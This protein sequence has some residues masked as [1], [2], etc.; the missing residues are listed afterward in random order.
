MAAGLSRIQQ[1]YTAQQVAAQGPHRR[2]LDYSRPEDRHYQFMSSPY[3]VSTSL[4]NHEDFSATAR[5]FGNKD[6]VEN[7]I[8]CFAQASYDRQSH[9]ELIE[10]MLGTKLFFYPVTKLLWRSCSE[11]RDLYRLLGILYHVPSGTLLLR[12]S[13]GR[14]YRPEQL[15]FGPLPPDFVKRVHQA[16]PWN[17]FLYYASLIR[18][19]R[20]RSGTLSADYLAT[21]SRLIPDGLPVLCSLQKL[22]WEESILGGDHLL[23][24]LAPSVTRLAISVPH[25]RDGSLND[26]SFTRWLV[27][28]CDLLSVLMPHL[29]SLSIRSYGRQPPSKSATSYFDTLYTLPISVEGISAHGHRYEVE[30]RTRNALQEFELSSWG[31]SL[32]LFTSLKTIHWF[33][34]PSLRAIQITSNL[35]IP[36][37]DAP[38][39]LDVIA[40]ILQLQQL[41]YIDILFTR[42]AFYFTEGEMLA[43]AKA[44]P[45]LEAIDLNFDAVRPTRTWNEPTRTPPTIFGFCTFAA[46][47]PSLNHA[48]LP[49][50]EAC[51]SRAD[52]PNRMEHPL[53]NVEFG[54]L[55]VMES[56][57]YDG[58]EV[59]HYHVVQ[60][61]LRAFPKLTANRI[62]LGH[63]DWQEAPLFQGVRHFKPSI[64]TH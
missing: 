38:S 36:L 23:Y 39:V 28:F 55:R 31:E 48:S 8:D 61:L 56:V 15:K 16:L 27:R 50:L 20:I 45:Q 18:T 58:R 49:V 64:R 3:G 57:G 2:V 53:S 1:E 62:S 13:A 46:L 43:I 44:F 17:H 22:E 7:V 33:F 37:S 42:Q 6:V 24:L 10:V 4:L 12:G 14:E 11:T 54:N 9:Q 34:T 29:K 47:C 40:P 60:A 21:I 41:R 25:V 32:G 51:M 26:E 63:A 35:R 19:A 59:A 52:I 5:L 30:P